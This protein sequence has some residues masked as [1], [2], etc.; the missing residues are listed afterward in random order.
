MTL[1]KDRLGL[2]CLLLTI[3]LCQAYA[4]NTQPTPLTRTPFLQ[5]TG[6]VVIIQAQLAP[7][8]DTLQFIFDTGSSGISLDSATA[9]YLGLRPT[10]D[11]LLI[12]GIAGIREVPQLRNQ[13]L[14]IGSLRTDSLTFYINDYSVLTSIY[15]VRIDGVIGYS[16]LSRYIVSI[17]YEKQYIE[18]FAPGPY[19]YPRKGTLL[20]PS[21]NK[22]PAHPFLIQELQA[23]SYPLLIDIGAGLNMLFS[24]RFAKEAGVLDPTRKSWVTSGEGI[25]GQ[26]ELRLTLLKSLRI[27]PYRFKK[28]PITI[29]DDSY[30]VTNY[31]HWA[32]LIGNDLLRRFNTVLNYPAAEIHLKPN[33]FFYDEFDYAYIGM[34]LYL[35]D[36]LIKV[37]FVASNSP[38]QDA[39]L[40]VGDEIVAVNKILSGKLDAFKAEL[41]HASKKVTIIYKRHGKIETA[42]V[43]AIRIK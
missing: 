17:D 38:A 33:R 15:G 22:L 39:G 6:G 11:G 43:K 31:P 25:G 23:K 32:G 42:I 29:F 10:F 36:G 34:E 19:P 26:I 5:V 1:A 8:S 18:W 24:E 21:I 20:R 28:I 3:F 41:A 35:I 14:T 40:E 4:V 2:Y 7:F 27:G 13:S 16:L 12:R 30:N 9:R 37:G